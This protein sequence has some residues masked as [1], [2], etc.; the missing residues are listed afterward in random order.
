MAKK[1]N[2]TKNGKDYYRITKTIG[3]KA[4]GSPIKKE[5][6]G[7]CKAEAEE[8]ANEYTSMLKRGL[9]SNYD[10]ITIADGMKNWL[11]NVLLTSGEIKPSTFERYESAYRLYVK[12]SNI[13]SLKVF[14][15][16]P[17]NI[18]LYY[19][20]LYKKGISSGIIKNLNKVLSIFFNYC[21]DQDWCIKNP[22][23]KRKI[24]IPSENSKPTMEED[25]DTLIFSEEERK[26]IYKKFQ[27]YPNKNLVM[28]SKIGFER[29]AREGE[30]LALASEDIIFDK[31]KKI[32]YINIYKTLKRVY[33]FDKD[34]NKHTEFKILTPKS[35]TSI[36]KIPINDKLYEDLLNHIKYI[37]SIYKQNNIEFTEKSLIFVT[38]SC[39]CIDG[40]NF[41]RAWK[42]FLKDCDISY[43][44]FHATRHDCSTYLQ[45]KGMSKDLVRLLLGHSTIRMTNEY[46]NYN[47]LDINEALVKTQSGKSRE[48]LK[49]ERARN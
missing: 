35:K 1:T 27:D 19:N 10:E 36:R 16:K 15:T 32:K 29:G 30:I 45:K 23:E 42:R 21:I 20:D 3:K 40:K 4:D 25:S 28:I 6:Y 2:Y 22:C 37:K 31:E 5:F 11:F 9:A 8:K 38:D 48:K 34:E 7:S 24:K 43:R 13:A 47:I 12:D 46:T 44:K 41:L 39:N 49:F 17:I 26:I 14:F 18:Q 33:I